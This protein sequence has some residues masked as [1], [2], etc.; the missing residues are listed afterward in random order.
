MEKAVLSKSTFLKGLQCEK[1]LYLYK[2]FYNL[3]D[4]VSASTKA[5]FN[6]GT[7]IGLLAQQLFPD[8][9]DASPESYFNMQ[10]SVIK[11]R[12]FIVAGETVIYEA[13]FQY[14]S[15]IAALDILV[16]DEEGWKGYEVKS[17][18]SVKEVNIE[19]AGIQLYTIVNSG[20]DL[21]DLSIIHINKQ[22]ERSGPL[23]IDQL[24]TTVSVF[25]DAKNK[26]N[27]IPMQ[28]ERLKGVIELEATPNIDIGTQCTDPY[29]CDF[30]GH[31]WKHIPEYSVFDI[32]RL[33]KKKK[34]EIYYSGIIELDQVDLNTI[35]LN[36]KQ[37]QQV[38]AAQNSTTIIDYEKLS[39]FLNSLK[40]PLYFLDFET[41]N[42]AVPI[43][44]QT[45]PYQ[46][47]VFQ[48]S[49]HIQ[50]KHGKLN[51]Q[52]FLAEANS[53]LDPR[54]EF[55]QQLISDCGDSGD[56]IVYNIGFERSQLQK[57][58][59][60]FPQYEQQ[61]ENIINRLVDLMEPFQKKWYYTP[62]MQGS[63]SIKKVLPALAP[64]LT[65][66]ELEINNG[67]QASALF[68]QM[69]TGNFEGDKDVVLKA[70]KNYCALDTFA[71]V[72]ILEKLRLISFL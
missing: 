56:I 13:T 18:T 61:I 32:A 59:P 9:A 37:R 21:V 57:L 28:V 14:N 72:K 35:N 42:P 47:L 36:E 24:L 34:F 27:G 11:T 48:Y 20:I 41:I 26:L 16:K 40:Y 8:G 1:Q 39:N 55:V 63:Y 58:I 70:L 51:H 22:Y 71:M 3:K 52:E 67:D 15:V 29:D 46:Q 66:D 25:E 49:L 44:N 69:L 17:S 45:R 10:E 38:L 33:N 62:E 7:Q 65:Y 54:I 31:C 50:P 53:N 60:V 12:Q 68:Y 30:I 4:P 19:D 23:D 2:H 43:Y 64:E 6:Q 5:I